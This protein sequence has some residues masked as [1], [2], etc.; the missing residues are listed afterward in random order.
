MLKKLKMF[1]FFK[2]KFLTEETVPNFITLDGYCF[3]DSSSGG[4]RGARD[5]PSPVQLFCFVLFFHFMQF[6][7]KLCKMIG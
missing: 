4:S 1:S 5:V 6:S 7:G 2:F 3:I